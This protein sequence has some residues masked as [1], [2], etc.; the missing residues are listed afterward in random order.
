[1]SHAGDK[2]EEEE[3]DKEEGEGEGRAYVGVG[4]EEESVE[5]SA[6]DAARSGVG[7]RILVGRNRLPKQKV[8]CRN[9]MT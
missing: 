4:S 3:E 7:R 6:T 8:W 2:E 9:V 1:M 5:T